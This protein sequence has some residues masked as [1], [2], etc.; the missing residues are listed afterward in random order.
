MFNRHETQAPLNPMSWINVTYRVRA[1]TQG[2]DAIARAL[3]LEQS[4]ELPLDA[5]HDAFVLENVV[6]KV[7]EIR[8]LDDGTHEVI[9][10]LA[11]AT[12]GFDV[13]QTLN[14]LFGNSS[15]QENVELADV[16]FPPDFQARFPGPRFGIEGI[17][18]RLNAPRCALTC[19]ALKPQGL[20][21]ERL[22]ALCYTLARAG[23]DV[24]KDDHGLADQSYAPFEA[25][26]AACQRAIERAEKETGRRSIY[27]PSL[28]GSPTALVRQS[29]FIRDEGVAMAL[30]APALIGMP[31]FA[32]LVADHLAVP[33]MAHPAYVGAA[34]ISPPFILGKWF[35]LLGADAVIFP[36]F[37]GRFAYSERTC[38]DIAGACRAHW[39]EIPR[40]LPVP[41]GGIRLGRA[42]EVLDF[43]GPDVMLLIGGSL[44]AA[45]SEL[46]ARARAFADLVVSHTANDV[47]ASLTPTS[48]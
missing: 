11:T 13:A 36:H 29:R 20:A 5:I 40:S 3:A 25:R 39:A 10:G 19:A 23:I 16:D 41:A 27:A 18:A 35:R 38:A 15:L 31:M 7:R 6:G 43:Y 14:M 12:T 2:I 42:R 4:V 17:R 9:V 21:P 30:I 1:S 37:G 26:V 28:V 46:P 45:G 24:I 48:S 22:A 47:R 44:L 34:R 32:E 8:R 33:I